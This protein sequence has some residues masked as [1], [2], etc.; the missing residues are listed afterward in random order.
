MSDKNNILKKIEQGEKELFLLKNSTETPNEEMKKI[1]E[2]NASLKEELW[3]KNIHEVIY[4]TVKDENNSVIKEF[5]TLQEAEEWLKGNKNDDMKYIS[6]FMQFRDEDEDVL[7]EFVLYE[8][9]IGLHGAEKEILDSEIGKE[10][11]MNRFETLSALTKLNYEN[12][13]QSFGMVINEAMDEMDNLYEDIGVYLLRLI[14]K[15]K[16]DDVALS[17][18]DQTVTAITGYGLDTLSNRL[19]EKIIED[20]Q[21]ELTNVINE[22]E[23][24]GLDDATADE[25]DEKYLDIS[26]LIE[27]IKNPS[28]EEAEKPDSLPKSNYK[29]LIDEVCDTDFHENCYCGDWSFKVSY[30]SSSFEL[31]YKDKIVVACEDNEIV[32]V[33][34]GWIL[35][36]VFVRDVLK[37]ILDNA[38]GVHLDIRTVETEDG[39]Y[40]L[41][42]VDGSVHISEMFDDKD[43]LALCEYE[44][45]WI[46]SKRNESDAEKMDYVVYW[47]QGNSWC[48]VMDVYEGVTRDEFLREIQ[49]KYIENK[50]KAQN[51]TDKHNA[52]LETM[53]NSAKEQA[54]KSCGKPQQR[55]NNTKVK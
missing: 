20:L 15:N 9:K 26:N 42:Y 54:D 35:E 3:G 47:D 13:E 48:S 53:I 43:A 31:S 23:T 5:D 22:R 39:L 55:E 46:A 12:L 25:L 11:K 14:E 2:K 28:V 8:R 41:G 45:A 40:A 19:K 7:E 34:W 50:A 38:P 30:F 27:S 37:D 44:R 21:E 32:D 17:L 4:Y 36:K 29:R 33:A 16:D 18:I 51:N 1:Q 52:S 10:T 6:G 49:S 24:D